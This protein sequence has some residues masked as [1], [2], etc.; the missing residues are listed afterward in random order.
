MPVDSAALEVLPAF[1]V[2]SL[3]VVVAVLVPAS[4]LAVAGVPAVLVTALVESPL[5]ARMNLC[6]YTAGLV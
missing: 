4:R 3:P 1:V 5:S 6:P 2:L